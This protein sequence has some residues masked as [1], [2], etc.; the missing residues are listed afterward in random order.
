MQVRD[1]STKYGATFG[2]CGYLAEGVFYLGTAA[3]EG[4]ASTVNELAFVVVA[5]TF[6]SSNRWNSH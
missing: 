5:S 4:N 3:S 6:G 1:P 2:R